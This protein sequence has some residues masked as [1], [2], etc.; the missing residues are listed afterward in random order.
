M[1]QKRYSFEFIVPHSDVSQ[2]SHSIFSHPVTVLSLR[3]SPIHSICLKNFPS[4]LVG[5]FPGQFV[6]IPSLFSH[7]ENCRSVPLIPLDRS[8]SFVFHPLS[9]KY[10][11]QARLFFSII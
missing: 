9:M 10:C 6:R 8:N 1:E 7:S 2:L 4:L 5:S 3:K 11:C